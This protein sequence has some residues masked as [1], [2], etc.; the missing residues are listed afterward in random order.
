MMEMTRPIVRRGDETVP[1]GRV[2]EDVRG[3]R[4]SGGQYELRVQ[5]G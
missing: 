5:A 2:K 1:T 3:R 4:V